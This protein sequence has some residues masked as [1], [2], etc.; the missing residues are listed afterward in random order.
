MN[1]LA[2]IE[3]GFFATTALIATAGMAAADINL[4]GY[5]RFGLN[6]SK[7]SGGV[8]STATENRVNIDI[9]GSG[10]NGNLSWGGKVRL[11]TAGGATATLSGGQVHIG[12]G[13]VTVYAGNIPGPLES[14]P[15][16]YAPTVGY[17]GG[18]FANIVTSGDNLAYSSTGAGANG[19]QVNYVM[20]DLTVSAATADGAGDHQLTVAY[21][22]GNLTFA[23]GVQQGDVAADDVTAV[24]VGYSMGDMSFTAGYGDNNG[25]KR[26]ALTLGYNVSADTSVT[27]Y[28]ADVSTAGTDTAFG[29]GANHS[30]GGGVSVGA[31]IEENTAGTQRAEIGV[32]FGF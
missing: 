10:T 29:L 23:A 1:Y 26:N 20:G 12:S 30:L 32:K 6:Q 3:Q 8:S 27:V 11:R 21:S 31:G 24:T 4:S 13:N 15:G 28:V 19:V 22:A 17:T 14:M 16:V 9:K 25:T 5:G 7:P 2:R 18:N